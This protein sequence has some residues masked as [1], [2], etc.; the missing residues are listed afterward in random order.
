MIAEIWH[1]S[2]GSMDGGTPN[3][4]SP[5]KLLERIN[6]N[7]ASGWRL[8][9]ATMNGRIVGFLAMKPMD[10]IL[11]QL[12]VAPEVQ[13][14]G[15]GA[16]LLDRAKQQLAPSFTLRTP[17]TNFAGQRFYEKHGLRPI[18]DELHP[19]LGYLVRY[20]EWRQ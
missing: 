8:E 4:D 12:F 2:A 11:D 14:G 3:R 16:A 9:V 20:F 19:F 10:K 6:S 1:A 13:G 17:V 7:L 18:R 5:N 15:I